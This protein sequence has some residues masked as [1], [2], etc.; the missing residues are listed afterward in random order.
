M[1]YPII[2]DI[3]K[4]IS[5]SYGVLLDSGDDAGVALR[6]LFI[7]D[8]NSI[9]RHIT[10]NDLPIGRSV[11]EVLRLVKAIQFADEHG[12]VCPIDWVPGKSTIKANPKESKEYFSK[13]KK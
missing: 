4:T 6:G 8:K 3:S 12:E 5:E 2:S 11:S 13:L 1:N 10:V 7:M 9:V